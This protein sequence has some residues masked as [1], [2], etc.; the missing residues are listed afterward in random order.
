MLQMINVGS[1]LMLLNL[2]WKHPRWQFYCHV[3]RAYQMPSSHAVG[4]FI[5]K[6]FSDTIRHQNVCMYSFWFLY[7]SS[8]LSQYF[9]RCAYQLEQIWT[10]FC[11]GGKGNKCSFTWKGNMLIYRMI[12]AF[13]TSI[14]LNNYVSNTLSFLEWRFLL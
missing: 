11:M 7:Y 14:Y 1:P 12:C 5:H 6:Y 10:L 8:F 9:I 4:V 2:V 3:K 13:E